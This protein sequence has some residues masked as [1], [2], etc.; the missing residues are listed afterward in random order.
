MGISQIIVEWDDYKGEQS[1][2]LTFANTESRNFDRQANELE[3]VITNYTV[4][5]P[6]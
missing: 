3:K 4:L 1:C 6:I 5:I 2:E